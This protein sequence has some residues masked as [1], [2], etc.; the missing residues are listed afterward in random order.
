[1]LKKVLK[2]TVLLWKFSISLE[3][4][5]TLFVFENITALKTNRN[6]SFENFRVKLKYIFCFVR[7]LFRENLLSNRLKKISAK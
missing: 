7:C 2:I 3:N 4:V 5:C 1:M 6:L